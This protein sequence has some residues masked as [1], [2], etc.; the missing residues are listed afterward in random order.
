[1]PSYDLQVFLAVK[2]RASTVTIIRRIMR[3]VGM[4]PITEK[5]RV[6]GMLMMR[7]CCVFLVNAKRSNRTTIYITIPARFMS[8][9]KK[10]ELSNS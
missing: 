2:A 3:S 8:P 4:T 9:S 1:M 5:T 7:V 10:E 6:T